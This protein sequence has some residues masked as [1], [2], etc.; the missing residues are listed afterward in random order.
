MAKHN[1]IPVACSPG[2]R[3]LTTGLS[4]D[5]R[6]DPRLRDE[7]RLEQIDGIAIGHPGKEISRR[8]IEAFL[9]YRAR[10]EKHVRALADFFPEPAENTSRLPE[11][12]RREFVLVHRAKQ[13]S[14][15]LE[16]GLEHLVGH[17]DLGEIAR[18]RGFPAVPHILGPDRPD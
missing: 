17:S 13:K 11:L 1:I 7:Q 18:E 2:K 3:G 8:G 5:P 4:I 15:K 14:P 6:P 16:R 12:R 9:V 10:I